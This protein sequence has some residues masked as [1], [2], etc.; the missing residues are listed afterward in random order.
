MNITL[1][2]FGIGI[3]LFLLGWPNAAKSTE[4]DLK[5]YGLGYRWVQD[6]ESGNGKNAFRVF[7]AF[8]VTK[9]LEGKVGW[10]RSRIDSPLDNG[11]DNVMV[12]FFYKFD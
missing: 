12:E 2:L 6:L 8:G 11:N 9:E 5:L 10:N 4:L 3:C 1:K 7:G